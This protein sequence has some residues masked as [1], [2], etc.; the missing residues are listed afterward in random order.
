MQ[1]QLTK[2][3]SFQWFFRFQDL[4]QMPSALMPPRL[5]KLICDHFVV[6]TGKEVLGTEIFGI[7]YV[8]RWFFCFILVCLDRRNYEISYIL[9][10][11]DELINVD[12]LLIK[13]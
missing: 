12:T 13:S 8:S 10:D 9:K 7:R 11:R 3:C 1:L 5:C 4:I 6:V 2:S